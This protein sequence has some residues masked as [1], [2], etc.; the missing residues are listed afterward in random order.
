MSI[1][2][3]E[4]PTDPPIVPLIPEIDFI[5]VTSNI[6]IQNYINYQIV[7]VVFLSLL[8]NLEND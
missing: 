6:F 5:K 1:G 3:N 8:H 2:V 4:L 7:N